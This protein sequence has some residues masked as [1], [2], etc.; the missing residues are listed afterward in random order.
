MTTPQAQTVVQLPE[1]QFPVM[2]RMISNALFP[3]PT[4]GRED[5]VIWAIGQPHPLA[6]TAKVV[7]M[8]MDHGGIEIYS[9]TTEKV[10]MRNHIPMAYVRLTEETMPLDFF[11]DL[12]IS[13]EEGDEDEDDP[14]EPETVELDAPEGAAVS[15]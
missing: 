14:P 15:S 11:V 2:T 3:D 10:G 4:T 1:P 9:I 13:A 6:S 7:R 8:F 5:P 12:L